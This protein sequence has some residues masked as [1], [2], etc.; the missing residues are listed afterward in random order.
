MR[1][2]ARHIS[3]PD[4]PSTSVTS[5]SASCGLNAAPV[6]SC[7]G[8]LR[9]GALVTSSDVFRCAPPLFEPTAGDQVEDRLAAF[10]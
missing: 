1:F 10:G 3:K 9:P 2:C 5:C 7:R 4:Q 6:M 8:G